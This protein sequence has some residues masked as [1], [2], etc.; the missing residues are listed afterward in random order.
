MLLGIASDWFQRKS[1]PHDEGSPPKRQP[2]LHLEL[3]KM[4]IFGRLKAIYVRFPAI[5]LE[6]IPRL[7]SPPE[8]SLGCPVQIALSPI[9]M[10]RNTIFIPN[11]CCQKYW[12]GEKFYSSKN[13]RWNSSQDFVLPLWCAAVGHH[14]TSVSWTSSQKAYWEIAWQFACG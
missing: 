9:F 1:R 10:M 7:K 12:W 13:S 5:A 2:S 14:M 6:T 4:S 3:R 11:F 8:L